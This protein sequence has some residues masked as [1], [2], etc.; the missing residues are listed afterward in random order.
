MSRMFFAQTL[1]A[2]AI[3][4]ATRL[5]KQTADIE[6]LFLA[7]TLTDGN[8]GQAMRSLGIDI[9]T[10]RAAVCAIDTSVTEAPAAFPEERSTLSDRATQLVQQA[11]SAKTTN[12][13]V[14]LLTELLTE[15]SGTISALLTRLETTPEQLQAKLSEFSPTAEAV[16]AVDNSSVS[17]VVFLP[18]S[19]E[20]ARDKLSNPQC[21]H[22]WHGGIES[23]TPTKNPTIWELSQTHQQ[24][25]FV[26]Q[27]LR[28]NDCSNPNEISWDL[29][30]PDA[31]KPARRTISFTLNPCHGG[32]EAVV[33]F[34]WY[35][36]PKRLLFASIRRYILKL[37]IFHITTRLSR[38]FSQ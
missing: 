35:H 28:R 23:I 22:Y 26:R 3:A 37:H 18:T 38:A 14:L 8:A 4:E 34:Q 11:T 7:L 19:P 10:A 36:T 21:V 9:A 1:S 25:Q 30:F 12:F 17:K 32:T 27:L 13:G 6:H 15:P 20:V 2:Q 33:Q 31:K 16:I 5:G 24:P 29:W